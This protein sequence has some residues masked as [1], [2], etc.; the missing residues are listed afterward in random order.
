[1]TVAHVSLG[2]PGGAFRIVS[3]PQQVQPAT[4]EDIVVAFVPPGEAPYEDTLSFETDDP[5]Q[6][7]VNVALK[8]V[9]STR[10]ALA[11]QPTTLDFGRV[12]ECASGFALLTLS[13]SGSADLVVNEIAFTE[14]TPKAYSFIGSTRTPAVVPSSDGHGG[15]G[16][17]QLTVQVA[18][19]AGATGLLTG[20]VRLETTD[21]DHPEVVIPLTTAVNR[22]PVPNIGMVAAGAPGQLVPLDGSASV[23]PDGDT[24]LSYQW[25]LRSK[26]LASVTAIAM[27]DRPQTSMT[28]DADLPGAYEVELDVTD[29]AGVRACVPARA[30]VVAAPAQKLLVELF[31]DN[32]GTDLDLHV[33]Q[34][35]TTALF[36][37]PDDCHFQNRTP[38]WGLPG[39][40]D[41]PELVRDALT[42]YGPEVFGYVDPINTTYRVAV[43]FNNDLLSPTPASKATVR[44]YL[45]GILRAE[46]SKT[47]EQKGD[48]WPVVDVGWPS[49]EVTNVP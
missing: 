21:P 7:S 49:G 45:S 36:S 20:G 6:P 41:D 2:E 9:G 18:V 25:T 39:S 48:V 8:G 42:G 33:L 34:S 24:P 28:L 13:S 14:D 26:P 1:M 47:L 27:P 12:G 19:P 37:I 38:D 4:T 46:R 44:V 17:I 30:T 35:P 23:D 32:A 31:W 11:F 16:S 15:P 22:A 43:V 5:D 10:A 29:A 40:S 3:A